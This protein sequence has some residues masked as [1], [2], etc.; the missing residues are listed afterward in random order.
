MPP[1][2]EI[3]LRG[4]LDSIDRHVLGELEII[5]DIA[6]AGIQLQR[7]FVMI[8]A[9]SNVVQLVMG[10]GEVVMKLGSRLPTCKNFFVG[11]YRSLII[12]FGVGGVGLLEKII[13][14]GVGLLQ[15]QADK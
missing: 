9:G 15:A 11:F 4:C 8:N 3:A 1:A 5:P 12:A 13:A 10:I 2:R 14:L 7:L 6:V